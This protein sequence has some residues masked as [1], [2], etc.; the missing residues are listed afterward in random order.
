M[1]NLN[2][3]RNIL[4]VIET[5]EWSKFVKT[6]PKSMNEIFVDWIKRFF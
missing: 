5:T 4:S 3:F 1:V 2:T 6:Q